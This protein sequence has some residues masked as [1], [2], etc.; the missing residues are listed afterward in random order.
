MKKLF[1]MLFVGLSLVSCKSY[2]NLEMYSNVPMEELPTD[3]LTKM[4]KYN[5][6][7]D[8]DYIIMMQWSEE[9]KAYFYEHFVFSFEELETEL[10]LK[11]P[12]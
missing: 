7:F 11:I 5:K 4:E 10:G 3:T 6:M 1:V 8:E 12:N 2:T 9:E